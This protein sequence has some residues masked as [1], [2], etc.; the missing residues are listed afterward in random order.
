MGSSPS[1]KVYRQ[2]EYIASCSHPLYAAMIVAGI[3]GGD[4]TI[5]FGHRFVVWS[6]GREII[7]ASESYDVVAEVCQK[8]AQEAGRSIGYA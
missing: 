5:R 7:P 1:W 3:G 8:R 4:V 2:K 6:E